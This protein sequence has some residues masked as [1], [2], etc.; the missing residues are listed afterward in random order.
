[1]ASSPEAFD[2]QF[3]LSQIDEFSIK[4]FVIDSTFLIVKVLVGGIKGLWERVCRVSRPTFMS[5]K[6]LLKI[7]V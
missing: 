6:V 1:M 2:P 3:S 5:R 4:T 7:S